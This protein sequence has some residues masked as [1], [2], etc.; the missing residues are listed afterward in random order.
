MAEK[1]RGILDRC[2]RK[3]AEVG[4]VDKFSIER[5]IRRVLLS[6]ILI[7]TTHLKACT[8]AQAVLLMMICFLKKKKKE[9]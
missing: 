7:E 4:G 1:E 6:F 8:L 3:A 2:L 9:P 5:L